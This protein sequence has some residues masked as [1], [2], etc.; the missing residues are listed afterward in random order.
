[1]R[2]EAEVTVLPVA[3]PSDAPVSDRTLQEL[4]S[5]RPPHETQLSSIGGMPDAAIKLFGPP[6]DALVSDRTLQELAAIRPPHQAQLSSIGGMPDAAIKLFG[7]TFISTITKFCATAEHITLG[8]SNLDPAKHTQ[9]GAEGAR[10]AAGMPGADGQATGGSGFQ[11]P[12]SFAPLRW[13]DSKSA[14]FAAK[15]HREP[16][17][18]VHDCI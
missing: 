15:Q 12:R 6:P 16:K 4:A 3:M 8:A 7:P 11:I 9:L 17:R 13:V 2:M 10:L 1:M 5:I 18:A 14:A